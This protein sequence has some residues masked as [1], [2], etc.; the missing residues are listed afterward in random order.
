MVEAKASHEEAL[1]LRR[2]L[3]Y[4]CVTDLH[5]LYTRRDG[6]LGSTL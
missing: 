3:D 1:P 6:R 5:I 2:G 4:V